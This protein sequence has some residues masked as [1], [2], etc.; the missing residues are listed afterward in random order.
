MSA[1]FAVTLM[2]V[3]E[4]SDPLKQELVKVT[5]RTKV[6]RDFY[7]GKGEEFSREMTSEVWDSM[8]AVL[9]EKARSSGI[10]HKGR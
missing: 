8:L 3:R 4:G 7:V 2:C 1:R 5:H 6:R 10:D 9:D